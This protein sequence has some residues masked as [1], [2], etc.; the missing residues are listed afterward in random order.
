LFG[1]KRGGRDLWQEWRNLGFA[2]RGASRRTAI[3]P[4]RFDRV[5]VLDIPNADRIV[6]ATKGAARVFALLL[7]GGD[8]A[9][10]AE[11]QIHA[12]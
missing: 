8:F 11:D 9:V 12:E 7:R 1:Q 5:D 4:L 6:V 10:Q 3:E 2:Q